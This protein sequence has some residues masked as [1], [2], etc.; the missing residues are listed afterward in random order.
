MKNNKKNNTII[1]GQ[2][3]LDYLA[4]LIFTILAIVIRVSCFDVKSGDYSAYLEPWVQQISQNGNIKA[5]SMQIGDYTPTYMYFLTFLSYF[6]EAPL[7]GIK[8]FSSIFDFIIAF[9]M[10]KLIFKRTGSK[11][12]AI[13]TY[14]LT[15]FMPTLIFNGAVWGQ[16]DAIYCSIVFLS[17]YVML[18][19]KD[20]KILK[21]DKPSIAM[22]L[23][24][25][26][27]S[28]K[29]QSIFVI[30]VYGLFLL[31]NKLKL[32]H[33]L[34]I[35]IVYIITILPSV[36]LGRGFIECLS[37]YMKQVG[38]YDQL[39]LNYPNIY[40]FINTEFIGLKQS[41]IIFTFILLFVMLYIILKSKIEINLDLCIKYLIFC[42]LTCCYFLPS[43]HERYGFL[44]EFAVLYYIFINKKG[45]LIYVI[46]QI[47]T[48]ITYIN[49]LTGINGDGIW[50]FIS[51]F[52]LLV[53]M[54]VVKD[55]IG[56]YIIENQD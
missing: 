48:I 36:I 4:I 22:I 38:G 53:I 52:R 29:L 35:P 18:L 11:T 47:T 12:K 30:P 21:F 20:I 27:F 23:F 16:C 2:W 56:N 40:T 32:R 13:I 54:F 44:A 5:L 37:I 6:D 15:L 17:I 10:Y 42:V 24:G 51:I 43:M 26:A 7:Y 3:Q 45:F 55:M 25:L 41:M 46:T 14:G 28:I 19:D 33:F 1:E 8:I 39:T 49:Y 31:K 9:T 34:Y 50:Y